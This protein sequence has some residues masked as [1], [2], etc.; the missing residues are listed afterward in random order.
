MQH[1][2]VIVTYSYDLPL[3]VWFA[4]VAA[5]II[6]MIATYVYPGR[7]SEVLEN[8]IAINE[9]GSLTAFRGTLAVEEYKPGSYLRLSKSTAE[10]RRL[11]FRYRWLSGLGRQAIFD[12]VI[13]DRSQATVTLTRKKKRSALPFSTFSAVRMRE[14]AGGGRGGSY[15]LWHLELVPTQGRPIRFATSVTGVLGERGIIFEDSAPL[16]KAASTITSLPI[17]A[18]VSWRALGWPP[19]DYHSRV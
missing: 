19:S 7:R 15:S 13:F 14:F 8:R 17:Q 12:E 9:C 6:L 18:Y 11:Q 2:L 10:S 5:W 1:I 16:A 3:F 4:F